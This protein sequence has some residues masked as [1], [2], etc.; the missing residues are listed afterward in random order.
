MRLS[1]SAGG[2]LTEG[3]SIEEAVNRVDKLMYQAKAMKNKVVTQKDKREQYGKQIQIK[4]RILVVDDSKMNREILCEMLKD[5]FEI[6]EAT[7]GQDC[8]SLIEQYG[9]EISL[10]LLDIVMPVMDG[11]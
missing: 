6:I 1:I 9:K 2:V 7:N 5:D 11:F 8:V 4:Q 3:G 10:V